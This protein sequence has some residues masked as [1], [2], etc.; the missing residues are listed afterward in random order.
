MDFRRVVTGV[1]DGAE[2][3][4]AD[5]VVRGFP[6]TGQVLTPIFQM[7]APP[8]LPHDGS[9]DQEFKMPGP[10]G[11]TIATWT[12]PPRTTPGHDECNIDPGGFDF[13]KERPGYHSTASIDVDYV[14]EGEITLEIEDG[15]EVT[16]RAGEFVILHGVGHRWHNRGDKPAAVMSVAYGAIR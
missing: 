11:I 3:I 8:Q 12:V 6:I 14:I 15:S 9:L 1:R 2:V 16:I 13:D 5:E 4:V 10:G 7:S